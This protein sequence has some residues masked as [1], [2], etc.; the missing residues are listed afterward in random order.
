M[1][2]MQFARI[3]PRFF[4]VTLGT[5][6][7]F[8]GSTASRAQV[9]DFKI[10][11]R[12]QAIQAVNIRAAP[13][14][15]YVTTRKIGVQG[16][17]VAGPVTANLNGA[18][19]V[20]VQVD[21]DTG[22]D[23]WVAAVG[24]AYPDQ[25]PLTPTNPQ[26]GVTASSGVTLASGLVT[27]SW[28]TMAKAVSYGLTVTDVASNLVVLVATPATNGYTVTLPAGRAYFWTVS[29]CDPVGCSGV[30]A[31]LYFSTPAE[32]VLS[33]TPAA[34]PVQRAAAGSID[35]TV[36][37]NGRGVMNWSAAITSTS[38][39]LTIA[40][41]TN[42]VN[43]GTITAAF[44]DNTTGTTRTGTIV[45]TASGAPQSPVTL[46]IAQAGGPPIEPA[47][48]DIQWRTN[49]FFRDRGARIDS[50][51]FH[52]SE[53]SSALAAID[54]LAASAQSAHYVIDTN[55]DIYQTVDVM[56]AAYHASYYN[57][58]SIGIVVAGFEANAS[59]WNA[60]AMAAL[61]NLTAYLV[62]NYSIYAIHPTGT[63][64]SYPLNLYTETGLIGH[65]QLDTTATDPGE[66]F[67]WSMFIGGVLSKAGLTP[68]TINTQPASVIVGAGAS[69]TFSV[70][71]G[72]TPTFQWM[73][74]GTNL[75]GQT[76][77]TLTIP[78][79]SAGDAG[80]I[81]CG[82]RASLASQTAPPP[83][84][85][86]GARSSRR[87]PRRPPA[88]ST[89][90]ASPSTSR[91]KPA[92]PTACKPHPTCARGRMSEPSP[93]RVPRNASSMPQAAPRPSASI[94]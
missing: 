80:L 71:A 46:T 75:P 30:T 21:F 45:V 34:P 57:D 73:H 72:S 26:P 23:G 76:A 17:V 77:A 10:G 27:F 59:T 7:L 85:R 39:W 12:V 66:L 5:L 78:S 56:K 74:G 35:F 41:A 18:P 8:A 61:E 4:R 49:I 79:V 69:A 86:S 32:A 48:L 81:P 24:L 37:N 60:S 50:I 33:V 15:T 82:F 83:R 28:D 3:F 38:P 13:A 6:L 29:A 22:I 14:G 40:S 53:T 88:Q 67:P 68:P 36:N 93:A 64:T 2:E 63:A 89:P 58:R 9:P 87:R 91:S 16:T 44:A 84:L 25:I 70:V 19:V 90:P 1:M 42:G 65:S 62:T 31:P 43:G 11:D 54:S 47:N 52:T 20:W 55:G 51:V 94:A 92:A